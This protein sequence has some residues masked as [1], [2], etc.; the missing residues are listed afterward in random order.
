M[1]ES[2]LKKVMDHAKAGLEVREEFFN[3]KSDQLVEISRAVAVC[4]AR[5]GKVMFCGNGGSAAD[6]QHLAAEFVNRFKL[7][8]PPL[9]GLALSTDTS[10]LT[11]IGNDYSYDMVFEKQ[12][13]ALARPGDVLIGLSTSGSSA[14]VIRAMREAKARE[15][16]TI[17]MGG[18]H[19]GEMLAVSDYLI[20][21]PSGDTP[22]IQEIHIAAGHVLCHL[23]DHFLFEAVAELQPWLEG[24]E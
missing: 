20:Q 23:V 11:A 24:G 6:S 16:L 13:Q 9:P 12:V 21:V 1:S 17:G 18:Q 3:T 15:V 8:R 10:I 22:V 4:L 2:A 5:G 14:N 7:E 19:G